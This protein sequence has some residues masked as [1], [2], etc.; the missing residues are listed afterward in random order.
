M[1]K[2]FEQIV[3]Y[4]FTAS[5]E[6]GFDKISS[7]KLNRNDVLDEFYVPF[8]KLVEQSDKI[9]RREVA[10]SR[11]LGTDPKSGQIILARLG[12]FGPLFQLG[13]SDG[14]SKPQFAPLPS[15]KKLD[16]VTLEDALKAFTLPRLVGQTKDGQDIKVSIGRFGP[17]VQAG[18]L[19]ASIKSP[20]DPYTIHT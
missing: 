14:D 12:R 5:V 2:H 3:N 4:K 20:L 11:E 15:G 10:K 9:D 8:H 1:V 7:G 18:S 19:Y 17:Y 16:N 6:T 13:N